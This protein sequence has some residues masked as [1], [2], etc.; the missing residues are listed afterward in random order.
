MPKGRFQVLLILLVANALLALLMSVFPKGG[1]KLFPEGPELRFVTW[2]A[3]QEDKPQAQTQ[4]A[5][6]L[7]EHYLSSDTSETLPEEA[8]RQMLDTLKPMDSTQF[9][10]A[11]SSLLD[12]LVLHARAPEFRNEYLHNPQ[13][14][15]ATHWYALDH[16]F[17]HA[18]LQSSNKV[19]RAVH[20]GDSQIEGDRLSKRLRYHLQQRF[21]GEGCG[22]VPL[23][24]AAEHL[25]YERELRSH[26]KRYSI[27]TQFR[28]DRRYG[29][30]G[31]SFELLPDT[32]AQG[33]VLNQ[34]VS[35][36]IQ[37]KA[38]RPRYSSYTQLKLLYGNNPKP[39]F[40]QL[41]D[42]QDSLLKEAV[43]PASDSVNWVSLYEFEQAERPPETIR[44]ELEADSAIQ[45]YGLYLEGKE[46]LQLD[47][48]A[49]R[50]HSGYGIRRMSTKWLKKQFQKLG[51]ELVLLQFG[52]NAV[53]YIEDSAQC[54]AQVNYYAKIIRKIKWAHPHVSILVI[55]PGAM[56]HMVGNQAV[57]FEYTDCMRNA[58]MEAAL[59]NGAAFYDLLAA[60]GG[61]GAIIPWA[62]R[63][64]AS[65][66]GHL[67]PAGRRVIAKEMIKALDNE[68]DWFLY[69]RKTR[70]SD[71]LNQVADSLENLKQEKDSLPQKALKED[72]L[73]R[74]K[75][76]PY[77]D[78]L[79]EKAVGDSLHRNKQNHA[80]RNKKTK[81]EDG[82]E[83]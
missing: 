21:G 24:S 49:L 73:I 43:L 26:W 30:S 51:V 9:F 19:L 50:G 53:P 59:N 55:G 14:D 46:G 65:L 72:S 38:R 29:L 77:Q 45:V 15:S 27:F 12:S 2:A 33:E 5:D 4:K 22:F 35:G 42:G 18:A 56:G 16:F 31:M 44:L 41:W 52:A 58:Q 63:K 54:A 28:K 23:K 13:I 75:A 47:N 1:W 3:L 39:F 57:P 81:T 80:V 71:S 74:K 11:D 78:S 67:G 69:R 8:P 60:M 70:L 10:V 20:Y 83:D 36:S 37:L 25:S 68:W 82:E 7:I 17:L 79:S 76:T 61:K 64:L 40:F 34:Q 6:S 66:D 32:N 48:Y 62:E